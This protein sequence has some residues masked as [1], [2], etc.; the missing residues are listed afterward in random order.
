MNYVIIK[1]LTPKIRSYFT[2][3]RET[4][5]PISHCVGIDTSEVLGVRA[6]QRGSNN[7]VWIERAP[8]LASKLSDMRDNNYHSYNSGDVFGRLNESAKYGGDPRRLMW[9][10]S[11]ISFVGEDT[12]VLIN[13]LG[14]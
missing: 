8:N 12:E 6:G 1:I 3:L 7:L 11:S 5:F 10:R 9:V 13:Q 4:G 14:G 2:N